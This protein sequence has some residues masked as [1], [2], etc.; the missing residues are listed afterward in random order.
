MLSTPPATQKTAITI[1]R[2]STSRSTRNKETEI[3]HLSMAHCDLGIGDQS[4]SVGF[5]AGLG[6]QPPEVYSYREET[7]GSILAWDLLTA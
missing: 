6:Y 4:D 7:K 3:Q 5:F 2:L 1:L